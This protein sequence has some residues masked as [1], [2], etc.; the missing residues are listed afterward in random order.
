MARRRRKNVA[1]YVA[2]LPAFL[3]VIFAYVFT[4]L[5][6]IQISF[7]N[8]KLLPVNVFVGL[9]QYQRLWATPRWTLSI[10]NMIIFGVGMIALCLVLGFLLA[11]ALDQKVRFENTFRTIFLYPFA[12]SFIVTGLAWQ[13]ILNPTLGLQQAVHNWGWTSF[14]FDWIVQNNYAIY[15]VIFAG[16]WQA[17]G[18]VMCILLAGLRGVDEELWKAAKVDGIPTWRVYWNIVLPIIR[19]T[20]ITACVL[21]SI[22]VVKVYELVLSLTGGGPGISS[23][24]PAKFIMDYLFGRGNIGLAT[25]ASTIMFLAV[26]VIL[27]PWLYFEYFRPAKARGPK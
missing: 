24:V 13:W 14:R 12:M 8:S 11:V 21:L 10:E 20:I 3:I 22:A 1:V 26:L 5:W 9:K 17:S 18:L 6:N 16:V 2:L 23:E 15:V 7:T 19:P 25:A 4:I 27:T